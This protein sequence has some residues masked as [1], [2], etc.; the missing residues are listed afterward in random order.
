MTTALYNIYD[1]HTHLHLDES[2]E[3]ASAASHILSQLNGAALM[4][5]RPQDWQGNAE[6]AR[7]SPSTR[8]LFGIHPWFAHHYIKDSAWLE[9]LRARLMT[10][11]GSAV[12]EIG[13]DRQWR[14]PDTGEVEY[15]AQRQIFSAQF[16]LAAELQLPI[17]VHCVKAQGDLYQ[18][19]NSAP[20]LPPTIYLHAFGGS[21]GT[22]EQLV[23][24]RRF[25]SRLY[26][27]FAAC[28]NL[29]SPKTH[30]VISAVPHD[31]LVIESDRS[32]AAR[33]QIGAELR[34]MLT[35][36]VT[37]KSE[38]SSIEEAALATAHNAARLYAPADSILKR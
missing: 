30:G 3:G 17:S 33:A 14:T 2:E 27:G 25:G 12:G 29:R 11:P 31:R 4:S 37:A 19:L 32:S 6:L 8:S 23:N 5:T 26:F 13:L 24:T 34:E 9:A 35:V 18:L 21:Q 15:Q 10:T 1:A 38:W 20:Q 16:K 22:V 7:S 28:I 36:Y